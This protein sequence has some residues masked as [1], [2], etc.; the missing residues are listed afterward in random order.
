MRTIL[1]M[2]LLIVLIALPAA[3]ERE[4]IQFLEDGRVTVGDSVY[5]SIEA[6]HASERFRAGGHRCATK[7]PE[8]NLPVAGS[9]FADPADCTFASTTIQPEYDFDPKGGTV[10]RV[11]VVFHIVSRT[12]G[13][14]AV[15]EAL[16][17]SQLDILNEDFRALPGS[18]GAPGIDTGFEFFLANVDPDGL[19]TTGINFYQNDDWFSDPGPGFFN[20][21]KDALHW[22][23]DR[24][25]NIYSND[26]AGALG[27]ATFPQDGA[28]TT[29]DGVVLLW[30]SVGRD[31][32]NGGIYD[33]G[34]TGTH[35][36]GHWLGIF[37]TFSGGCGD[38]SFPYTTGDRLADTASQE[39]PLFNCPGGSNTCGTLDDIENY[40]NYTQ[41]TCMNRFTAEQTNRMRCSF[42]NYR[43]LIGQFIAI[44][45]DDFETGDTTRWSA[46]VGGI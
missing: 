38:P 34:R 37:H 30:S 18:L 11:P 26:S 27:Y 3:A 36:I 5:E 2:C 13:V 15:S 42:V 12:N 28:G 39:F 9:P 22:D 43:P 35:E 33:K 41:D 10:Y 45:G 44:F 29:N 40:M 8:F 25:L 21:M 4:S 1:G 31:A 16:V 23:T 6:F 46:S 20:S 24:Y 14:G 7:A 19:P 17:R 32:P